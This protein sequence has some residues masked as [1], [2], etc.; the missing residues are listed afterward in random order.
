M[1]FTSSKFP[2]FRFAS[3][4]AISWSNT[5]FLPE[6]TEDYP[7]PGEYERLLLLIFCYR[8]SFRVILNFP[9][10]LSALPARRFTMTPMQSQMRSKGTCQRRTVTKLV[11]CSAVEN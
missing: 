5:M 9:Y 6:Q 3:A 10:G 7:S 2:L 11:F 1:L 4:C 8:E